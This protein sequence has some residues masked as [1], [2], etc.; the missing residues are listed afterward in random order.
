MAKATR[1]LSPKR[2]A[3]RM[4][5][6]HSAVRII[7]MLQAKRAVKEEIRAKGQKI[8]EF[9][10]REISERADAFFAQHREELMAKATAIVRTF[11]EFA[12]CSELSTNAQSQIPNRTDFNHFGCSNVRCEM[13]TIGYARV[14]TD[15]QTLDAQQAALQSAGCER[16]FAE[17]QSGAKTNRAALAKAIASLADG[18]CLIVT[19]LDRLARS[20]RDLLNTLAAIADAG[21]TFKSLGDGWCDTTSAHGRL[22]LTVLGGLAEFER[23]L[24]LAR[25]SEGRQRAQARG[26]RFGRSKLTLHQQREALA[27]R[28]R[29]EALVDIA[30][31]YAVSH[32]TISRLS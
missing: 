25:T 7:A 28:A 9:S 4:Q 20:T 24:I 15:S 16:V 12:G 29:G 17:K 2:A 23:H 14:S 19:K 27:R 10:C 6:F 3:E 1:S 22:M 31:S 32:S 18:D 26:V 21:A 5:R 8:A 11:P 30:R 13:T